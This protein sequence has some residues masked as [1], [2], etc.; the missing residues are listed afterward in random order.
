[1][2][3]IIYIYSNKLCLNY[4]DIEVVP[5]PPTAATAAPC[6]IDVV[7]CGG[8]DD[9]ETKMGTFIDDVLAATVTFDELLE[10]ADVV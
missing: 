1:M 8:V 2:T 9:D 5:A 10:E 7:V 6:M 3:I 4:I